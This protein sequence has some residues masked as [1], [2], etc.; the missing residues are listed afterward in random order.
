MNHPADIV[1]MLINYGADPNQACSHGD[2]PVFMATKNN[3]E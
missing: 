1:R 2:T 3:N